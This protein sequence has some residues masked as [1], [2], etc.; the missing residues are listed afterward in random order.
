[1]AAVQ[2][3]AVNHQ[4]QRFLSS[5][6]IILTNGTTTT[7]TNITSN[8]SRQRLQTTFS[9]LSSTINNEFINQTNI[10]KHDQK[11]NRSKTRLIIT[12]IICS[13]MCVM[14]IVGNLVVI[15]TVCLVRK[16]QTASNIL[17]VSLAVSD[18]F[19]GLFIMPLAMGKFHL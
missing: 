17:I 1:V 12:I 8:P 4:Q 2:Q 3:Q 11:D 7:T 16:L 18:I 5:S 6:S 19:V 13:L 14:T 9:L 10:L 15:L